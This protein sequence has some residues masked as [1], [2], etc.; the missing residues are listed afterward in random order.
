MRL[1]HDWR[2]WVAVVLMLIAMV[3]YLGSDD[4]A[5]RPHGHAAV[6]APITGVQ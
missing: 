1:H 5:W 2:F 4:L 3:V 6:P